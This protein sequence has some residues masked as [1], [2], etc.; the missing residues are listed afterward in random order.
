MPEDLPRAPQASKAPPS[1]QVV[2]EIITAALD[3]EISEYGGSLTYGATRSA[4]KRVV[5]YLLD[6]HYHVLLAEPDHFVV[7]RHDTWA[8]EHALQ[9]RLDNTLATCAYTAAVGETLARADGIRL[10]RYRLSE[11]T[12]GVVEFLPIP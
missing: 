10:G 11:I 6:D 9:C 4:A 8:V 2:E 3:D 5:E 12:D 7:L 1:A